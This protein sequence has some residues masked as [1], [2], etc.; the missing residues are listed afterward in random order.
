[1]SK[2]TVLPTLYSFQGYSFISTIKYMIKS[3]V[4]DKLKNVFNYWKIFD[5]FSGIQ[6]N[7]M[8][9]KSYKKN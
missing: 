1:M 9:T 4:F 2:A 8:K 5:Y 3:Q 6:T 7:A